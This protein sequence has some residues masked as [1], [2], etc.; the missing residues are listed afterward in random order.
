MTIVTTIMYK[1]DFCGRLFTRRSD[2]RWHERAAH[3]CLICK[4]VVY[5]GPYEEHLD[6]ELKRCRFC[7]KK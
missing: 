4:H 6:C 5:T 3:K 1:C 2:C 7:E